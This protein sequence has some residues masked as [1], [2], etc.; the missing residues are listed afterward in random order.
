MDVFSWKGYLLMFHVRYTFGSSRSILSAFCPHSALISVFLHVFLKLTHT[1]QQ[2]STSGSRGG[3]YGRVVNS[4]SK[5]QLRDKMNKF[6]V[7]SWWVSVWCYFTRTQRQTATTEQLGGDRIGI[8]C[9][10]NGGE[11][12]VEVCARPLSGSAL[13]KLY[14]LTSIPA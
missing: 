11:G 10:L 7:I 12:K 6:K 4:S 14:Y 3:Q 9:E 5:T 1:D 2:S 13:Q 8:K